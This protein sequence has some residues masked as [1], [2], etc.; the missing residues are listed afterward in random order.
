MQVGLLGR[1]IM[2]APVA[3]NILKDGHRLT[4]SPRLVQ[5]FG[6]ANNL[7]FEVCSTLENGHKAVQSSRRHCAKGR[8]YPGSLI[9]VWPSKHAVNLEISYGRCS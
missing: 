5:N 7:R 9:C 6:Q 8:H 4:I 2:G 3:T 1:G